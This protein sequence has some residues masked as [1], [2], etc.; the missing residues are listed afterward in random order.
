MF[1]LAFGS[2]VVSGTSDVGIV[3]GVGGDGGGWCLGLTGS[4]QEV[5][6]R[7]PRIAALYFAITRRLERDHLRGAEL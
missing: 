2:S 6:A 1:A 3:G 5:S 4:D 7:D